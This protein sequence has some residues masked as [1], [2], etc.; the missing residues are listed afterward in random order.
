M[1]GMYCFENIRL[2]RSFTLKYSHKISI[3]KKDFFSAERRI[4][5]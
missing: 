5:S 3:K 1:I 2:I 4:L